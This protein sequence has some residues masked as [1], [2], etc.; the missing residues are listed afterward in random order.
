MAFL[1]GL[2]GGLAD[3]G[4]DLINQSTA[5]TTAQQQSQAAEQLAEQ[6]FKNET[7]YIS[8]QEQ[9]ARDA[10]LGVASGLGNPYAN[11]TEDMRGPQALSGGSFGGGSYSGAAG[12]AQTKAAQ[13][14]PAVL[15]APQA[16]P[17]GSGPQS[18]G[19][20][21][22]GVT[23]GLTAGMV[24]A[25]GKNPSY[26][27]NAQGQYDFNGNSTDTNT[28]TS[29]YPTLQAAEQAWQQ[30]YGSGAAGVGPGGSSLGTKP[31]SGLAVGMSGGTIRPLQGGLPGRT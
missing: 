24:G 7:G 4:G 15:G 5:E 22:P 19:S 6:N 20:T 27:M 13:N 31:G 8:N 11:A 17:G 10:L 9:A 1:A 26:G 12:G 25:P 29:W 3:I 2:V 23:N 28:A 18:G 16:A 30:Q 14:T 21:M